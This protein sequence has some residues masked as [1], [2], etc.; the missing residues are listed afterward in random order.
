[1]T[2]LNLLITTPIIAGFIVWLFARWPKVAA[3]VGALAA[4]GMGVL[5]NGM[6][7]PDTAVSPVQI[8]NQDLLLTAELQ[9]TFL[10]IYAGL[11]I[12]FLLAIPFPQGNKF[13][14]G[15]LA[16]LSL[17]SA[18]VL[19][20]PF[21]VGILLIW[22]ALA[23]VTIIIQEE[24]AGSTQGSLT[25][26]V[27]ISIAM[28]LLLLAIWTV[29][30]QT[31]T[32][33]TP[34]TRFALLGII[35]L[36]AGFPFHF[37]VTA[38]THEATP[39][40]HAFL[41]GLVQLIIVTMLFNFLNA[42]PWLAED[43]RFLQMVRLSGMV[44][45]LV[46]SFLALTAT[47]FVHIIAALILLDMSLL[48][49]TL[50]LP[51]EVGIETAVSLQIARFGSLILLSLATLLLQKTEESKALNSTGLGRRAPVGIGLFIFAT[52]SLIGFPLTL[53]FSTHFAAIKQLGTAVTSNNTS[54]LPL[55][56]LMIATL[57]CI[58]TL[59]R[60]VRHWF[61]AIVPQQTVNDPQPSENGEQVVDNA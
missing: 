51:I 6:I 39:L 52:A 41:L 3:A 27:L 50:L 12:L 21:S 58:F 10:F 56:L 46:V 9:R 26:F 37:W 20:R 42:S 15:S 33:V 22:L 32:L 31:T 49:F 4:V 40:I 11:A 23:L 45:L 13:V 29:D 2:S 1:M 47:R 36:L 54:P 30:A 61:Q 48:L 14:P 55:I 53:G 7:V 28:P 18:A 8:F 5:W 16:A 34:L 60:A 17:M 44:T 24:R 38:V 25:Y 35:I 43:A 59:I 57:V 19:I